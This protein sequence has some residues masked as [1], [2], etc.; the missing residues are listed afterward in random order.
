MLKH[1]LL[2]FLLYSF[3]YDDN[4]MLDLN[5]VI[6][7][8]ISPPNGVSTGLHFCFHFEVLGVESQVHMLGSAQ[9]LC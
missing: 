5:Y 6:A 7:G 9:T 4:L 2:Q 3:Y 1:L 8:K